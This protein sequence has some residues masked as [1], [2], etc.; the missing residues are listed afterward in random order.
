TVFYHYFEHWNWIDAAFFA[1][2]TITTVGYGNVVP[3]TP[4]SKAFT[5][6]YMLAGIGIAL[7]SL[8]MIGGYYMEQ[9]FEER[10]L[11]IATK[12]REH[13]KKLHCIIRPGSKSCKNK[14]ENTIK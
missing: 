2:S 3:T 4:L 12:P 1:A 9:R 13:I 8:S 5:I 11:N 14:R 10:A 7:Y 6:A